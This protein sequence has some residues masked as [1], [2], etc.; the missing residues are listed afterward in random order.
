MSTYTKAN[1]IE[2]Q[3]AEKLAHS[4][5]TKQ[6]AKAIGTSHLYV[7]MVSALAKPANEAITCPGAESG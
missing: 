1:E 5:S 2:I 6:K 7:H 3:R 4:V